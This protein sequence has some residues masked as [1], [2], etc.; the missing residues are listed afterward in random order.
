MLRPVKHKIMTSFSWI[1]MLCGRFWKEFCGMVPLTFQVFGKHAQIQQTVPVQP[2]GDVL[3][4]SAATCGSG[5]FAARTTEVITSYKKLFNLLMRKIY[6]NTSS[7]SA[8]SMK[9]I[10]LIYPVALTYFKRTSENVSWVTT[11]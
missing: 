7:S 2:Y 4:S 1:T 9:L 6:S 11:L 8:E 3:L 10:E 5:S